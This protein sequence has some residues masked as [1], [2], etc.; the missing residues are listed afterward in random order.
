MASNG[1]MSRALIAATTCW[2]RTRRAWS[3]I[4]TPRLC[5]W[6]VAERVRR[7]GLP[8]HPGKYSARYSVLRLARHARGDGPGGDLGAGAEPELGE[9]VLDVVLGGP[10]GEEQG[11]GDLPV[12]QAPGDQHRHLPLPP[13]QQDRPLRGR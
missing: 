5:C 9:D 11:P 10:L 12:G 13:R 6:H 8:A 3:S 4:S 7:A 2:I 1:S